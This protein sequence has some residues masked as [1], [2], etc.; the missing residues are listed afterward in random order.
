MHSKHFGFRRT[1]PNP[2]LSLYKL[3]LPLHSLIIFFF[4]IPSPFHL[5]HPPLSS[6]HLFY[7]IK[8]Q[9]LS[10][11]VLLFPQFEDLYCIKFGS[12][13]CLVLLFHQ[14]GNLYCWVLIV[15]IFIYKNPVP[16]FGCLSR[17]INPKF[18]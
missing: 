10:C 13:S 4:S 14:F 7:Q 18:P 5:L 16:P 17:L 12:L 11:L 2:S 6:N 8:F 9:S 1:Q 15:R 3:L